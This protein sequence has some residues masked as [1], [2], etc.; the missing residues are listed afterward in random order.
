MIGGLVYWTSGGP[1]LD[2]ERWLV[3]PRHREQMRDETW[4]PWPL[5]IASTSMIGAACWVLVH[6]CQW[7]GTGPGNGRHDAYELLGFELQGI[8]MPSM[9]VAVIFASMATSVP[10][11]VISIRDARGGDYDD[12]VANALGSNIFDI[13]FALG[14]PILVYTFFWGRIEIPV[15][16]A[17][18]TGEILVLLFVITLCG[19]V[20]YYVGPRVP[21]GD[22][23][24]LI[25]MRRGTAL[26]L[27][28]LYVA[29]VTFIVARAHGAD[30]AEVVSSRLAEV[31]DRFPRVA[32]Y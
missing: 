9:F 21:R 18:Q 3:G 30:W 13:C 14:L 15:E 28:L 29:F 25:E 6:A 16:T 32:G 20:A 7:L 17:T 1:L 5:L 10:D 11:T 27:I 31:L 24:T 2:L 26:T 22:G 8:G 23:T 12:A 4:N 19:F